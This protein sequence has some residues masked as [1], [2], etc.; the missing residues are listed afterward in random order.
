V[1]LHEVPTTAVQT[2]IK[3][4]HPPSYSSPHTRDLD[5]LGPADPADDDDPTTFSHHFSFSVSSLFRGAHFRPPSP[6]ENREFPPEV[7]LPV[8]SVRLSLFNLSAAASNL[9]LPFFRFRFAPSD[10]GAEQ[11]ITIKLRGHG[12]KQIPVPL[13]FSLSRSRSLLPPRKTAAPP[14]RGGASRAGAG[15]GI[16][17]RLAM[18]GLGSQHVVEGAVSGPAPRCV[19]VCESAVCVCVCTCGPP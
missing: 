2:L 19:R 9:S 11:Q 1:S 13:T 18:P 10:C 8:A 7:G 3:I 5:P 16:L 12:E 6:A 4:L 15:R 14:L 17:S